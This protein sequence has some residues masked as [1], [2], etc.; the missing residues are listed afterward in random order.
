MFIKQP[1]QQIHKLN[2]TFSSH[3][4]TSIGAQK[5]HKLGICFKK[6]IDLSSFNIILF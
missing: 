3:K 5:P 6:M 1:K 4:A 2:N